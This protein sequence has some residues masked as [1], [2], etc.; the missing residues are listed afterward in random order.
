MQNTNQ[1]LRS[2]ALIAFGVMIVVMAVFLWQEKQAATLTAQEAQFQAARASY[3]AGDISGAAAEL[4]TLLAENILNADLKAQAQFLLA[5]TI[6][7]NYSPADPSTKPALEQA[8]ATYMSIGSDAQVGAWIRS[9]ALA[10]IGYAYELSYF[11]AASF[12][13]LVFSQ[14]P[15]SR[16]YD[17]ALESAT[18]ADP[19]ALS[20]LRG[21]R[22]LYEVADT[23]YPTRGSKVELAMTYAQEYSLLRGSLS[24]TT[25]ATAYGQDIQKL[26][27]EGDALPAPNTK[28]VPSSPTSYPGRMYLARLMYLNALALSLE[29]QLLGTS[30]DAQI[31][32]LYQSAVTYSDPSAAPSAIVDK[33]T[34]Y[35]FII[36]VSYAIS[37]I[38]RYGQGGVTQTAMLLVPVEAKGTLP[39][40]EYWLSKQI[41]SGTILGSGIM[42]VARDIPAFGKTVAEAQ[43]AYPPS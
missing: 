35:N 40:F 31:D 17:P 3:A 36:R 34:T 30:A 26:L 22:S 2:V 37:I 18:S 13:T 15:Y 19:Y 14:S 32:S 39:S 8:L 10:S 4:H 16:Y 6:L 21:I 42:R 25:E 9:A 5:N 27:A 1:I 24:T 43:K 28:L 7:D 33:V 23:L 11:D 29:T 20:V 41:S 38:R 12:R